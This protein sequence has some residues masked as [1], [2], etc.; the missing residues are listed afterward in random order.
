MK[1]VCGKCNA[2]VEMPRESERIECPTCGAIFRMPSLADGGLPH[3]DTF[4]NYRIKAIIG[5][6]GMGTV[7]RA[8]Q[9][10]MDREVAIKVLLRKYAHIQRFVDRFE[11][12]AAALAS[13]NHTNIVT[14][15]DRGR[16]EDMYY[17]VMEFVR[18]RTLRY[19]IKN[20]LLTVERSLEIAV[21]VCDALDAA[22][23]EGIVHRDIKPGNILVQDDGPIRV[24]DFGIVHM[25]EVQDNTEQER[26]SRLGTAKYMAPEQ[27][28]TGEVIDPRADIYALGVTLHEMLTGKLP[29]REP[30]SAHNALVPPALDSIVEQALAERKED[31]FQSAMEMRQALGVLLTSMQLDRTPATLAI[32]GP[33]LPTVA[34]T[35]CGKE[36]PAGEDVC[37]HCGVAHS[38][39]CFRSGC[40]GVNPV[41][42]ERC[43]VCGGHL[44]LLKRQRR[45]E[46][47]ALLTRA[48]E[49]AAS[50]GLAAALA[51]Y[52][53]V[54]DDPH[55]DFLGLCEQADEAMRLIRRDRL[56]GV[57]RST[58]TAVAAFLIVVVAGTI[59]YWG[60]TRLTARQTP[61]EERPDGPNDPG[62]MLPTKTSP[63]P[64]TDLPPRRRPRPVFRDYLLALTGD[65]WQKQPPAV[66]LVAA[67]GAGRTLDLGRSNGAAVRDLAQTLGAIERRE[68]AEPGRDAQMQQLADGLDALCRPVASALSRD[69]LLR[70]AIGMQLRRH[71][72][73]RV[74][75]RD[76]Q[77]RIALCSSIL[78]DLVTE[79]ELVRHPDLDHQTRLLFLD[80]SVAQAL[81]QDSLAAVTDRL[82]RSARL[83]V[84]FLRRR[85]GDG[86][87]PELVE[88]A[89]RRVAQAERESDS[90]ARLALAVEALVEALG[91]TNGA[92]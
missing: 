22:H 35:A 46:L 2:E 49:Q 36:R 16:V 66:R 59:A 25:V 33:L 80:A 34:C 55:G 78:Y 69:P 76:P 30:A 92:R 87:A 8:I 48:E 53:E 7:Y 32:E 73:E 20:E 43:A 45:A 70:K 37:P 64:R 61:P 68:M 10:S 86:G 89:A 18:G 88:D 60:L 71:A 47:E 50:G 65:G 24:A 3:P 74:L 51:T 41:G 52:A 75:V 42:A 39:P 14:I 21:Q 6:G 90:V 56:W 15:I 9:L 54:A 67:C 26:L 62:T 82:L 44:E 77:R 72:A 13:L 79:A 29:T 84:R 85:Q 81:P 40:A 11:R 1:I 23:A 19:Y 17:L 58:A 27:R 4:P 31:R 63:E 38:E 91:S 83:L 28:G 5:H 12:E 57:V